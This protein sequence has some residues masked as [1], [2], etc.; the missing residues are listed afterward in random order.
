MTRVGSGVRARGRKRRKVALVCAG[1]GVTGA[2]YEIGALRALEDLLSRSVLDVDMYV[3]ISGGAF[4]SSLLAHGISPREMYDEVA[5]RSRAPLGISASPLFR[6][7]LGDLLLRTRKA[8]RVLAEAAWTAL[9]GEG[10]NAYDVLL[11]LFELLPAGLLDNSGIQ[12]YLE[13]VF[14][15][16]GR[17]DRFDDLAQELYVV[18]VDLDTAEAVAFGEEVW[19]DVPVSRAVQ[20]STAL[21]GLYRPVRIGSRDYVD[22]GVKKTAHINLAIRHGADL[23]ICIN[24]IVPILND[25]AHGPLNGHLSNKGVTYVLDQVLRIALHGRMQYGMERYHSEHPEVDILL[26]E[27]T[28]D[29][30]RMFSYNIMRYG[31]RK[32]VAEDGYRSVLAAFRQNRAAYARLL[33]RHGIAVNDPR[34]LPDAPPVHPYRS[35]VAR[36]LAGSLDVLESRLRKAQ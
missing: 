13:S 5:L 4:V 14:R 18:A 7:G 28:R 8:P 21:P 20:A 29:D 2:V 10:R 32:I 22:G 36:T 35:D 15:S 12:E 31:A 16:R 3:G 9:T 27:P 34:R 24:P 11:S 1:G 6:L 23:V 17:S 25:A 19:R 30:M 26:V 33:R